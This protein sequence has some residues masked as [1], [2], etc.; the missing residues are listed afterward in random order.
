MSDDAGG[1]VGVLLPVDR[2][3][4]LR[5][6]LFAV[7]LFLLG[8]VAQGFIWLT[9]ALLDIGGMAAIGR[10]VVLVLCGAAIVGAAVNG[11]ANDDLL[12][13]AAM[14]LAPVAGLAGFSVPVTVL[15]SVPGLPAAGRT[16]LL[17]GG[18]TAVLGS[19]VGL[20]CVFAGRRF[21]G[22]RSSSPPPLD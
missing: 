10:L 22:N 8:L 12:V 21:G 9:V 15:G 5:V 7:A 4:S 16:V 18:V 6:S 19:V 1:L 13:S 17:W 11:Y 20:A 14:A 2:G 3:V